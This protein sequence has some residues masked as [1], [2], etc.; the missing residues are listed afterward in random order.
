MSDDDDAREGIGAILWPL[1]TAIFVLYAGQYLKS[2][3]TSSPEAV[4]EAQLQREGP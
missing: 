2:C 4:F 3:D 1:A